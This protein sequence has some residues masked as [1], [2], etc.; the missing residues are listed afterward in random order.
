[1][2]FVF[3]YAKVNN[4]WLKATASSKQEVYNLFCVQSNILLVP[5]DQ[6]NYEFIKETHA[7]SQKGKNNL[8]I[9]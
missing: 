8:W 4:H 6:W 7:R 1:M 5:I 9:I 3:I 2:H